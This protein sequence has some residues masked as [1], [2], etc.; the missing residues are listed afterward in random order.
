MT[1]LPTTMQRSGI[2]KAPTGIGGFDEITG[3]GLPRGR[4]SLFCGTAGC[5]KTL[6]AME[7][8]VRGATEYGEP[9]V[10]VSFEETERDLVENVSSLGFDLD[11]LV[12]RKLVS[13][14]HILIEASEFESAGEYDLEGL[15]V[16]LGFAID[17]IGAKRIVLDTL[18]TLFGGLVNQATLRSELRRLFHWLKDKGVTAVITGERGE[19]QL[20][21]Q[22]LEEYV[23]DCVVLLDHRIIDQVSTRRLRIVKYRGSLHGTNEYPFLIDEDGISVLPI[24]ANGLEHSVSQERVPTG[25]PELDEM[26]GGRGFYQGSS[27]LVSGTA[28]TGKSTLAAHF[29]HA[30]CC[31]G[32]R[33]LYFGFEES[34]AQVVRNMRSIGIDLQP[35]LDAGLLKILA[36]RP[37]NYG[38]EMHLAI[39]LKEI[40]RFQPAAI[41]VD[42]V[43][44][45][46]SAGSISDAETMLM[47]LVDTLKGNGITGFFTSLIHGGSAAEASDVALSSLMDTWLLVRGLESNGER[48]RGLYVLKSRGMDHSN[49]VREFLITRDGVHLR[50]VYLGSEGVLTGSAR[51]SQEER[52]RR[53][54]GDLAAEAARRRAVAERKIRV[55][56]AQM[57]SLQAEIE[58][59]RVRF[60]QAETDDAA[61]AL[62]SVQGRAEMAR[63][64]GTDTAEERMQG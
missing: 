33:F 55:I 53:Q 48:N 28:G 60:A 6:F 11:D 21:R 18:E 25:V 13:I 23:S 63:S 9:G 59:E 44:T 54:I 19:G 58:S 50:E 34:A 49:Q 46:M 12:E 36:S 29:A 43:T 42:P 64:R 51:T 24:T 32:G 22:G 17:S 27:V 40:A 10:F 62:W 5:G 4:T 57:A 52:D 20:T 61:S 30:T 47:R 45:F 2:D 41:V 38:L 8:L 26:L 16:R 37:T 35:H 3:G 39:M 56:E 15:F 7:F 1:T 31:A 14:D